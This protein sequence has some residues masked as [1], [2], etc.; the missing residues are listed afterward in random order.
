MRMR[1]VGLDMPGT[2]AG[3]ERFSAE[4]GLPF[5]LEPVTNRAGSIDADSFRESAPDAPPQPVA[6]QRPFIKAYVLYNGDMVLCNCD[7][8]RTTIVGNVRERDIETLWRGPLLE[9]IREEQ[10]ARQPANSSLCAKCDYP[11][12]L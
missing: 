12:R 2:R 7:W 8:E 3:A 6:C 11:Y 4:T 5:F 9:R 10:R 1:V